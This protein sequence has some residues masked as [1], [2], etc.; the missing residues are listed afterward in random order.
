MR[1]D[2]IFTAPVKAVNIGVKLL[3]DALKEQKVDTVTIDWRPPKEVH[4]PP[5]I[6]EILSKL[7]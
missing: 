3:G 5:R 6:A 1:K 4:L 7:E 2:S